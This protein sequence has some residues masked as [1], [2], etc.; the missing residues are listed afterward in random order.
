RVNVIGYRKSGVFNEMGIMIQKSDIS[1]QYSIDQDENIFRV[2]FY[3]EKKFCGMLL[4][5]FEN[6]TISSLSFNAQ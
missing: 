4:M 5:N 3:R 1:R 2:E 6:K